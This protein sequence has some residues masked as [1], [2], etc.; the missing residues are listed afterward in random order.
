MKRIQIIII[1]LL[2][3]LTC[4][5]AEIE[6]NTHTSKQDSTSED[7]KNLAPDLFQEDLTKATYI[8]AIMV[9]A[10]KQFT[11]LAKFM[12]DY[13]KRYATLMKNF[14]AQRKRGDNFGYEG[15]AKNPNTAFVEYLHEMVK[16]DHSFAQR[17]AISWEKGWGMTITD[18]VP[19]L[20]TKYFPSTRRIAIEFLKMKNNDEDFGYNWEDEPEAIH[21]K[22]AISKW[23][24]WLKN[25]Q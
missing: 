18:I 14:E 25:K 3:P 15:A 21:N 10:P 22:S 24:E 6:T 13:P 1:L 20:S 9:R 16:T 4:F 8:F 5:A 17:Y 2:F 23:N 11:L 12:H 7:L 19:K